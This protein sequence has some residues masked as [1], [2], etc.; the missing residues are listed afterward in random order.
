MVKMKRE[1]S[2][3]HGT[4]NI[5]QNQVPANDESD[6]LSNRDVTVDVR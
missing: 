3:N 1:Q 5:F 2:S 6:K 4:D